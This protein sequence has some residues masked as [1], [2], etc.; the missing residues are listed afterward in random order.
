M[1]W[2]YR[3][4]LPVVAWLVLFPSIAAWR[5][6]SVHAQGVPPTLLASDPPR[7]S[8]QDL[9]DRVQFLQQLLPTVSMTDDPKNELALLMALGELLSQLADYP[10]AQRVYERQLAIQQQLGQVK[11][12][13]D[14][15]NT[16]A[17]IYSVLGQYSRSLDVLSQALALT[18]QVGD[19][20]GESAVLNSLGLLY[21]DFG[22]YEKA[23]NFYQQSLDIRR[24]LNQPDALLPQQFNNIARMHQEL[25]NYQ[26]ALDSYQESLELA[27]VRGDRRG[28]GIV[29]SNIGGIYQ[30]QKQ[31]QQA[32]ELYQQALAISQQQG[33]IT[34]EATILNNIG[35]TYH[36]LQQY[37]QALKFY[38]QALLISQKTSNKSLEGTAWQNIGAIQFRM[39]QYVA[40][41]T[42]LKQ[43]ISVMESLRP[44]LVDLDRVSLTD[45][46]LE[47]YHLL[48]AILV[49][50][51]KPEQALEI[52]E[53]GRARAFVELLATRSQGLGVRG[54]AVNT[55]PSIH[56]L[57][58]IN[59]A[60]IKQVAKE[61]NA[62]LVQYSVL[63]DGTT[64]KPDSATPDLLIWVVTPRGTITL[65]PVNLGTIFP[66]GTSLIDL[67]TLIRGEVADRS[68]GVSNA[69][70]QQEPVSS[71][72]GLVFS[73]NAQWVN[74]AIEQIRS[75]TRS[76]PSLQQLHQVLIAP[77]AD[78]LPK[79]P[80][81]R[82]IFIPQSQLFLVPFP[83]LQDRNGTYLVEQHTITTAPAIQVLQLTRQKKLSSVRCQAPGTSPE[84]SRLSSDGC[85]DASLIV[86]NPTM[87][88]VSFR[89]GD[90]PEPLST[91]P[92]A[93]RE[94]RT[95]AT[96]LQTQALTGNQATK[97]TV[98]QRI[99]AARIIH[100]ATHGLLDDFDGQG[101]PGAI[102]LAPDPSVS[103]LQ[104]PSSI[105]QGLLTAG[106]ILDLTLTADLV[107][108]S[109]CDT[110]RGRISGDGVIG[111]SRSLIAA[112]ASSVI[113]SLWKV[114]DDSTVLLMTEFYRNLKQG[115][116]KAQALR[117][118][119]LLTK[120]QY[121][122]PIDWA[123]FTL[124]GEAD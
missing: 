78:L 101:I 64:P 24:S 72:P 116:T 100:L 39:K 109:A 58:P 81:D 14:T 80:R 75:D 5:L 33:N 35:S 1:P 99:S 117:Q 108:L 92:G 48:Q 82:I 51:N 76:E 65:R 67:V 71:R 26:K 44:G 28:E 103:A 106:E 93:E 84:T 17:L 104:V 8:E 118:A 105:P 54:Q 87:P 43:A 34:E 25:K 77:I 91:L 19:R 95:I 7:E 15:L 112:G 18:R 115:Q 102:A 94:A 73:E 40:A 124:I 32:L 50:Q 4:A 70:S 45:T 59:I 56:S 86:G 22:Q 11:E 120:A 42:S 66:A 119:M 41:E 113:V 49:A 30:E 21:S 60:E 9:R 23:L 122:D 61:Q 13:A 37:Q 88:S 52:A 114:P 53:R 31:Y 38:Q 20:S 55:S 36:D 57:N 111:L 79:N 90:Q 97:S 85:S 27:R 74:Q 16:L 121:P 29:L 107:T 10:E 2:N 46:Q 83:A 6:P 110:G 12:V 63:Y 69:P 96:L 123:A 3:Y 68:R 98:L 47:A 89:L 62:T